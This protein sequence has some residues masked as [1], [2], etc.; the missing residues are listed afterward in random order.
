MWRV[1]NN[2]LDLGSFHQHELKDPTQV[3]R[4]MSHAPLPDELSSKPLKELIVKLLLYFE[5]H[6]HTI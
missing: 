4:V 3:N 6:G 2:S 1:E 5:G